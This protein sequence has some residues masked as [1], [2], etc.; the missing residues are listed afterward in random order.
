[1]TRRS[2]LSLVEV[3]TA[4]FI[5][6]LGTVAILT[7]FP[8]GALEMATAI[9]DDRSSTAAFGADGYFRTYWKTKVFEPLTQQP[10]G[11]SDPFYRLLANPNF[12]IPNNSPL[13]HPGLNFAGGNEV[14]YPVFVDPMGFFA[15]TGASQAWV[16]DGGN[17]N[18]RRANLSDIV[19]AQIAQRM[20]SLMDGLGYTDDGVPTNDRE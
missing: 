3:L 6:A 1:M 11:Q 9:R 8:L 19:N 2:G 17:T 14:G 20:C 12:G 7:M 13:F 4:L 5:L 15:R 10:V 18:I 16:G